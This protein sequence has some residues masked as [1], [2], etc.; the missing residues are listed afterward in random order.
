MSVNLQKETNLST[1]YCSTVDGDRG[2]GDIIGGSDGGVGLG[3]GS[4]HLAQCCSPVSLDGRVNPVSEEGHP[5]VDSIPTL[6]HN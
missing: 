5:G 2:R 6:L 3:V 4:G 1:C